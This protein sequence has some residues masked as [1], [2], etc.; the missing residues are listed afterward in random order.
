MSDEIAKQ[1]AVVAEARRE[2]ELSGKAAEAP[3]DKWSDLR[4][5]EQKAFE[6]WRVECRILWRMEE[7]ED[8]SN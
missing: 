8:G 5:I 4:N 1:K 2:M 6:A 3:M 7:Q